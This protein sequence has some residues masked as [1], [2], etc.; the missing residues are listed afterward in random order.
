MAA[1]PFDSRSTASGDSLPRIDPMS[2]PGCCGERM[3]HLGS[4]VWQCDPCG[5]LLTT[6]DHVVADRRRCP[7][8]P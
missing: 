1:L 8:H 3:E 2:G 5:C 7:D 4:G 6:K